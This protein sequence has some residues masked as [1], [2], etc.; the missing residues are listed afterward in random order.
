MGKFFKY[1]HN[2]RGY[3][4]VI[5]LLVLFIISIG[6][7][8]LLTVTAN[9]TKIVTNE[10]DYQSAYYIAESALTE[11]RAKLDVAANT[12]AETIKHEYSDNLQE[13]TDDWESADYFKKRYF[14]LL[15]TEIEKTKSLN[16]T[17]EFEDYFGTTPTANVD[18]TYV[19]AENGINVSIQSTGEINGKTRTLTQDVFYGIHGLDED[20]TPGKNIFTPKYPIHALGPIEVSNGNV[21]VKI[22]MATSLSKSENNNK[23]NKGCSESICAFEEEFPNIEDFVADLKRLENVILNP[24]DNK[25]MRETVDDIIVVDSGNKIQLKKDTIINGVIIAPYSEVYFNGN[26]NSKITINGFI[27]AKSIKIL[28]GEVNGQFN[29]PP[30]VIGNY[31]TEGNFDQIKPL[32]NP[33]SIIEQ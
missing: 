13:D 22:N 12:L 30:I 10:R 20:I 31:P 23:P 24:D 32:I 6:G 7:I 26:G 21:K 17:I 14:Y 25:F 9:T 2:E 8:S 16:S 3:T 1:Y 11:T 33:Q 18:F 29:P 27:L 15:K 19:E 4:L 5:V 28:N